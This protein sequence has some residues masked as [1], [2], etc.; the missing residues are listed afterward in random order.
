MNYSVQQMQT[1]YHDL[2]KRYHEVFAGINK[3]GNSE[4][5]VSFLTYWNILLEHFGD[6]DGISHVSLGSDDAVSV[7][8]SEYDVEI[9]TKMANTLGESMFNGLSSLGNSLENAFASLSKIPK[10]D[11]EN[12]GKL[13]RIEEVITKQSVNITELRDTF[14]QQMELQRAMLETLKLH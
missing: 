5:A 1:K 11:S 14:T 3:T 4:V 10:N 8:A 9:M 7:V 12:T 2:K 6:K 13:T